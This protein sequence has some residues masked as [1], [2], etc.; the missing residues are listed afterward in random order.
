[1]NFVRGEYTPHFGLRGSWLVER[2]SKERMQTSLTASLAPNCTEHDWMGSRAPVASRGNGRTVI[3]PTEH[4]WTLCTSE[5][6]LSVQ[7]EPILRP[8]SRFPTQIWRSLWCAVWL[9]LPSCCL[10]SR[11]PVQGRYAQDPHRRVMP[12][13]TPMSPRMSMAI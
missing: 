12:G 8:G 4:C 2:G 6:L 3:W 13:A 1:M 5:L 11:S 10:P 9:L 7:G